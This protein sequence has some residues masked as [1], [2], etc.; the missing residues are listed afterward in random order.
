MRQTTAAATP[1]PTVHAAV[2]AKARPQFVAPG[3]QGAQIWKEERRFYEANG[4]RLVWSGGTRPRA[5]MDALIRA[6]NAAPE[7]GLDPAAYDRDAILLARQQFDPSQAAH[8]DLRPDVYGRD[9]A[10]HS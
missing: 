6:L 10:Q 4:Y 3:G 2:T 1:D 5:A 9:R 8:L 7:E